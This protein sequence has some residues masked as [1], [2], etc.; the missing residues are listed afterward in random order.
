M[1]N[2]GFIWLKGIAI[3]IILGGFYA[4]WRISRT[5]QAMLESARKE[6]GR[7]PIELKK[8]RS[9]Y[10]FN[11]MR[12]PATNSIPQNIRSRE[13]KYSR[14]IP[15]RNGLIKGKAGNASM[16][17]TNSPSWTFSGPNDV[18]GRTRAL[19]I[20]QRDPDVIIAGGVS[21]G[22]WKST[23]GGSTWTMKT[24]PSQNMSVTWI[25]QDPTNPDVWY[26]ASGEFNGN[27]AS[28]RGHTA[29][30]TG[31]GVFKSTDN[32][33][34]WSR[35]P[36]TKDTD[37][38]WDSP[39]DY[40]TRIIVNPVNGDLF[41]ASNGF[42]VYRSTDG[43]NSVSMVL[44][45]PGGHRFV[46][47]TVNKNGRLLAVLSENSAG[48]TQSYSPGVYTSQD[49]GANW[50]DVTSSNFPSTHD[51]SFAAFAP[52]APDTAYIF[53]YE[54]SGSDSNEQLGFFMLDFA[55]DT[56][57]DRSGNLPDFGGK[58]GYVKTQQN[59]D[60]VVAVKPD[61]S[62]FVIVGGTNLFRS[63]NGFKT[64]PTG[65][66]DNSDARQKDEFW[67]G[68]Y[69]KSNDSYA[70]YPHHH[71]DQH[72]L[73]FD[74]IN[75]DR[76]WSG[77]DG[78]I[79][80]TDDITA[81]SVNWKT[82]D[83]GYNVTQFYSVAL[84]TGSSDN[85]LMG[86]SQDNGTPFF[87]I[88]L[89][90]DLKQNIASTDESSGDGAYAF[91]TN[92]YVFTSSQNGNI[93]RYSVDNSGNL[94]TA[95][96]GVQPS[97]ASN[98]LFIH[99]YVIDPNNEALMFYPDGTKLW[100]NT[101]MDQSSPETAW[102]YF[103]AFSGGN[104]HFITALTM[105]TDSA[106]TLYYAAS[107][108]ESTNSAPKI[109]RL[110][111]ASTS[112]S[113]VD[114]SPTGTPD[115]AYVQ[116]LVVNPENDDEVI[117][118]MSNYNIVGLY[119]TMDGGDTWQAIEGNLQG[120]SSNPGPSLR[121]A[122]IVPTSSAIQYFVG[123]ST[124]IYST[125]TLDGSN[126]TWAKE[127]PDNIGYSVTE[128]IRA[129]T[130][131]GLI[132]AATHGRGIFLGQV[133]VNQQP[134]SAPQNLT[135]QTT[136]SGIN[137]NWNLN[138]ENNIE[139]YYIY[140]GTD[141]DNL[142]RYDSVSAS[143]TSYT[144]ANI[145]QRSYFYEITAFDT[146]GNESRT[147]NIAAVYR[148]NVSINGDWQLVG[149]PVT[150]ANAT[151]GSGVQLIT[152]S[153]AYQS[154]GSL[155]LHHG[156]WVKS[157][158]TS[159]INFDGQA[160]TSATISLDKGWNL[161]SGIADTISTANIVDPNGILGSSTIYE[162]QNGAYHSASQIKPTQGYW[163]HADKSG[164]IT[165]SISVSS[166]KE[167]PVTATGRSNTDRV[168]FSRGTT[169]QSFYIAKGSI[170]RGRDRF[171]MAPVAPDPILDVRTLDGYRLAASN[172]TKLKLTVK[173]YP[174]E[175]GV[176]SNTS[177]HYM[178]KAVSHQDT[179]YFPLS[180][181]KSAKIRHAY[182]KL[183]L[184]KSSGKELITQHDLLPNYPNPF[185]PTTQ[186]RYQLSSRTNVILE[187][188]DVLGRRVKTLVHKE[189]PSGKYKMLFD[190]SHL[191]SGVYFVHLKAGSV[192]R[193]QKMTLIK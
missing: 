180:G 114:V 8:D 42:G 136:D 45:S 143:N 24:D 191:S 30:Y 139:K 89:N 177:A 70:K 108:L 158:S 176:V 86:G 19:G 56:T 47:I 113:P 99:P 149:S 88:N 72:V 125:S 25:A 11:L 185:N 90:G 76:L 5:D 81:S 13:L 68:G 93:N 105:T 127:S 12:D 144:D 112:T 104:N 20:D 35:L 65:G 29:F 116:R 27:S 193:I 118:V 44:G 165:L 157:S 120:N 179:L 78:G 54:G 126:T 77:Q 34:T 31:T 100:R 82:K 162:Y 175:V 134:P 106:N 33:E 159:G 49:D 148:N 103:T 62:D 14:S 140:R 84:P 164:N 1:E 152:F 163:V 156:Y 64:K 128:Q 187:V 52:S 189:Q 123:T 146:N 137:L 166:S 59:Y 184:L 117:A 96:Y 10:F 160:Q 57:E 74:P 85:R 23:D 79:S 38:S 40:I 181:D 83:Q 107:S 66:Y 129:R 190:G 7:N 172:K 97:G 48:G 133:S 169:T 95:T 188:F 50:T 192:S 46:D 75:P 122:A 121:G 161:I 141:S 18:G 186:I 154:A 26:Y 178:L 60:M 51:R 2:R 4:V 130:S 3:L 36:A 155:S 173:H 15:T 115:G 110:D 43:G 167:S 174:V 171:L 16:S 94:A 124:G 145:K 32:G 39:F 53:T 111:S 109:F 63:T 92:N 71:P 58:S 9:G 153:G 80:V 91:F 135:L 138:S 168:I 6:H 150:S 41:F 98:Q 21:G 131:D 119:H 147:S 183:Y 182:N 102:N 61:D 101:K 37:T 151:V 132:A 87:R 55:K 28:D 69:T 170:A 17:S 67:I 142:V 22:I 73:V